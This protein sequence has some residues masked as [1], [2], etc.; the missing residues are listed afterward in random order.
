MISADM[1]SAESNRD[2]LAQ[3]RVRWLLIAIL[4]GI[5][6]A[7]V[8]ILL[9]PQWQFAERWLLLTTLTSVYCLHVL[10][11]HLPENHPPESNLLL[12]KMGYGNGLTIFRAICLSLI[13]G[14]IFSPWPSGV[15]AWAIA[16]TYTVAAIA[17]FFD[18]FVARITHHVTKL[19][20]TLDMEYDGL[21]MLVVTLLAV[22]FGQLPRWY[23]L[24]GFARY[25][26]VF[27]LWVR[28]RRDLPTY[29]LH[30]SVHR[31]IFAGFQM[32]FM[33]ATIWPIVPVGMA[34]IGGVVFGSLTAGGFLRDWFVVIGRIDPSSSRY[35]SVQQP[36][37]IFFKRWLPLACRMIIPIG[38]FLI[39]NTSTQWLQLLD[40][41]NLPLAQ[42]LVVVFTAL[43]AVGTVAVAF[44]I[45][46]RLATLLLIVPVG[47]NMWI[48]GTT[49]QNGITATAIALVMVLGPG[50]FAVWPIEERFIGRKS[51]ERRSGER[52]ES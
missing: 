29:D 44:G 6:V 10:W 38:M 26:F 40:A 9:R 47:L 43:G 1:Q 42:Q 3:L 24:L 8:F 7:L 39:L 34:T 35:K 21:A 51:G 36:V 46:S 11:I 33:A 48:H 37:F 30:P 45:A 31:R 41:F 12:T 50:N 15:L 14:F 25:F 18:G 49:W 52:D 16:L 13:A 32:G 27:G 22:S 4:W 28:T 5:A 20:E 19:G 23:L 2:R 17:D